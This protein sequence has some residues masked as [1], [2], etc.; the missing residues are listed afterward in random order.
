MTYIEY[1]AWSVSKAFVKWILHLCESLPICSRLIF[2]VHFLQLAGTLHLARGKLSY[3]VEHTLPCGNGFGIWRG[4]F[5]RRFGFRK[6]LRS[7]IARHP[8]LHAPKYRNIGSS[9][10]ALRKSVRSCTTSRSRIGIG[11]DLRFGPMSLIWLTNVPLELPESSIYHR[12]WE[13]QN[14]ECRWLLCKR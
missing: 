2:F 7:T 14:S 5:A 10:E 11:L 3:S 9:E 13:H 8:H 12:P 1:L 6:L 4:K